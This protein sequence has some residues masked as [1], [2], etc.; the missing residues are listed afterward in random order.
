MQWIHANSGS[1]WLKS[2]KWTTLLFAGAPVT[3]L[4][5]AWILGRLFHSSGDPTTTQSL[6]DP[7]HYS[8]SIVVSS[9][10][11]A[12]C[13]HYEWDN[14]TGYFTDKGKSSCPGDEGLG[15]NRFLAISNGFRNK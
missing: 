5:V 10:D 12:N 13:H 11:H 1:G 7:E 3:F 8:G 4:L 2:G 6:S 9:P 14:A 15:G